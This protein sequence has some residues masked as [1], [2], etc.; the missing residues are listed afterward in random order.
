[1]VITVAMVF[2]GIW[3]FVRDAADIDAL[4]SIRDID[5]RH[6]SPASATCVCLQTPWRRCSADGQPASINAVALLPLIQALSIAPVAAAQRGQSRSASHQAGHAPLAIRFGAR[7][8]AR[9]GP[10]VF[11]DLECQNATTRFANR[12]VRTR[13]TAPAE[14]VAK[15]VGE[16]NRLPIGSAM[17]DE[18]P[19]QAPRP[20]QSREYDFQPVSCCNALTTNTVLPTR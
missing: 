1:V 18:I 15:V 9:G 14:S 17:F 6:F 19:S 8:G 3:E 7:R 2:I 12:N 4:I 16:A 10:A 20:H 13:A 11:Y 5:H